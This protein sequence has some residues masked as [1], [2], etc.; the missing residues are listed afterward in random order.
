MSDNLAALRQGPAAFIEREIKSFVAKATENRL[1]AFNNEPIFEEPLVGY[2]AGADP[3][4][5]DY[6]RIIGPHHLTP[7]EVM[8][9]ATGQRV[10]PESLTVICWVLPIEQETRRANRQQT[11]EPSLRWAHARVHSDP[12]MDALRKHLTDLLNNAGYLAVVSVRSPSF[13]TFDLNGV[14]TSNWSER[15]ALYAAGLGTFSLAD[16]MITPKGMAMRCGTL[17]TN[18]EIPPTPRTAK[19][20]MENCLFFADGSCRR[21]IERCPSG[22]ITEKGHNKAICRANLLR[23][24]EIF[25]ERYAG[26]EGETGCALCQTAVPCESAIPVKERQPATGANA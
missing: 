7:Q 14:R 8:E 17:T 22:A 4:F 20:H 16:T 15:H 11:K 18:L 9:G 2:A 23:M 24:K 1:T 5:S 3:I 26:W 19:H 25:K 12:L 10:P 21:C 13:K 6:K